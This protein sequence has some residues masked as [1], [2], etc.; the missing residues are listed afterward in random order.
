MSQQLRRIA[1]LAL[2]AFLAAVRLSVAAASQTDEWAQAQLALEK[3]DREAPPPASGDA[4]V[5]A[6]AA[7]I[8][9]SEFVFE[10]APFASAHASTMVE[11]RDGLVAAWFGGTREGAADV[12]IWLSR[13][14]RG[15]WASPVEV[16]TGGQP[17]GT[18]HPCWNPVLFDVPGKGLTLFYKVG[19]SPQTWWGMARSSSDGGRTWSDARRLPD[20][21]LGPIKNKPV[22][23]PDG[24][25]VNPSSTESQ[26]Q[27]SRWRVHFERS[28]DAGA[29]W[30]VAVPPASAD[31]SRIDAI[32][33]SIL[34]HPGGRLQA[35]GRTRSGRIF[36]TAS[37]DGGRTWTPLTLTVLPNPSAGTDAVTLRDGRHL[38]VYN[39]TAQ[40]R[41]PLNVSLS[42]DG[43]VW[44]AALVLESEPGEY[45][46][47]A[48]IQASDG[49]LHVSYTWKRQRIKHVVIDPAGLKSIPM[50]DGKW[51]QNVRWPDPRMN[52]SLEQR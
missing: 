32:Q 44:E 17:D 23:L 16:A 24:A 8:V 52:P 15:Q 5:R 47:P 30:T 27:P 9:R 11:T 41:S 43:T 12:G 7:A 39:H 33:P 13:Q 20:G 36:E 4:Q 42:R 2:G 50:S 25:L 48:V 40:G 6:G 46:Y 37:A 19:P 21:I 22:Q 51:P 18:R 38:L 14:E 45:S 3:Q 35:L 26:E 34:I 28:V 31:G 29:T 1:P 49:L 10:T